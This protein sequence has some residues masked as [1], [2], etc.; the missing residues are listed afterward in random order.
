M[1]EYSAFFNTMSKRFTKIN[2]KSKK[3]T[4]SPVFETREAHPG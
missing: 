2:Q 3:N 4:N 1:K